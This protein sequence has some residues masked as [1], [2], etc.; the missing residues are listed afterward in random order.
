MDGEEY[1]MFIPK[2]LKLQMF[3]KFTRCGDACNTI[4]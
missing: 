2:I 3:L 1:N 4:L